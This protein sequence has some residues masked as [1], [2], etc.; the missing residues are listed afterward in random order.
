MAWMAVIGNEDIQNRRFPAALGVICASDL[1]N[2]ETRVLSAEEQ[3]QINN[4]NQQFVNIQN[5]QITDIDNV[6]N[7]INNV[8]T[9]RTT[10]EPVTPPPPTNDTGGTP[11]SSVL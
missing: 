5:T 11:Q 7:V 9:N 6:I 4:I 1:N 2:P 3:Q 8:T 10:T